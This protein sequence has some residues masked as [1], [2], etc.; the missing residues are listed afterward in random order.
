MKAHS[1]SRVSAR[2]RVML[3]PGRRVAVERWLFDTPAARVL[4]EQ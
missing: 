3:G 1:S 2:R 4:G